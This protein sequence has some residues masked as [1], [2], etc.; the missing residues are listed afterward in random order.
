MAETTQ[1]KAPRKTS[2]RK[3]AT[4]TVTPQVDMSTI[5]PEMLAQFQAFMA[6]QQGA[7]ATPVQTDRIGR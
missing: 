2:T 3:K 1:S 4:D 5:T 6:M 7:V